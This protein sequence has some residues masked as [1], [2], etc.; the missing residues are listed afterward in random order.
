MNANA[1]L[2]K[3]RGIATFIFDFDGTLAVETIDFDLMRDAAM[4]EMR[5][6]G[7]VPESPALPVMEQLSLYCAQLPSER[8]AA[9]RAAVL[10]A[11]KHVE[12]DA[13]RRSKLFPCVR[14]M[15]AAFRRL[16]IA[17][18]I[19]TR[20][21]REAVCAVFPDIND[22][23]PCLVTRDDVVQVKPH[24][25][26][27]FTALKI[28]QM[29]AATCLMVGDHPMD[30]AVGKAAG[31]QTGAVA[32]GHVHLATLQQ[33]EPDFCENSLESLLRTLHIPV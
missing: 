24:P 33:C 9:L 20:N 28:L 29:Q 16:G 31:T 27:L 14:P 1:P 25:E 26:H 18:G 15:F 17:A 8:G 12:M 19:I 13:A 2:Y 4:A 11:V 10:D 32:S 5:Y 22:I 21:C 30:I 7:F 3:Q 23:C 6:Q